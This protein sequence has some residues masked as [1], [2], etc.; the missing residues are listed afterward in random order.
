MLNVEI[1]KVVHLRQRRR[2]IARAPQPITE[3]A[4]N[5]LQLRL[6]VHEVSALVDTAAD[7]T[8]FSGTMA[9]SYEPQGEIS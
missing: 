3:R 6:D 2:N 7:H 9:L 1:S 8:V 4:V 5:R